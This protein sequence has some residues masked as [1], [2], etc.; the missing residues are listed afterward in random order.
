MSKEGLAPEGEEQRDSGVMPQLGRSSYIERA[1]AFSLTCMVGP[2]CPVPLPHPSLVTFF[3][4]FFPFLTL[5][6]HLHPPPLT[7]L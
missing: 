1:I 3:P 7:F 6:L 5:P 4:P 2:S